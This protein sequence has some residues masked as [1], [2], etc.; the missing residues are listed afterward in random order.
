MRAAIK[1]YFEKLQKYPD[2]Y[3]NEDF[4]EISDEIKGRFRKGIIPIERKT[5]TDVLL[6]AKEFGYSLPEEIAEYINI[7]WHPWI[8][9]YGCDPECIVLFSVLKKQ[10]DSDDDIL[11][12][13]NS[14]IPL[15][16]EWAENGDIHCYIPIGWLG[17]SGSYVLYETQTG[18][19]FLEDR[20][21]E[22]KVEDKP[23]A[24]SLRDLIMKLDIKI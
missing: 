10:G 16:K 17:Y 20:D 5:E 2:Y 13:I 9:G 8:S 7:F 6:F 12:Y 18:K 19:I 14:L 1:S 24:N 15:A 11:Y 23:I 3:E 21:V 22:G 4:H